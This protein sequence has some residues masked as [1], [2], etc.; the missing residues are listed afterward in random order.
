MRKFNRNAEAG[1]VER[2]VVGVERASDGAALAVLPRR[3]LNQFVG[4]PMRGQLGEDAR[5][6]ALVAVV[7]DQ[8]L[9]HLHLSSP[10]RAAMN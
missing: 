3:A 6:D 8:P 9:Y 4:C 1:L 7:G 5:L 10:S 2:V